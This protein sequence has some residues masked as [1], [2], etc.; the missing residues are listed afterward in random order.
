M[1]T[2][3]NCGKA[4][5]PCVFSWS[6]AGGRASFPIHTWLQGQLVHLFRVRSKYWLYAFDC[7]ATLSSACCWAT[8]FPLPAA[9]GWPST[10]RRTGP[11]QQGPGEDQA[12]VCL[13]KIGPHLHH[14]GVVIIYELS[15]EHGA[16]S[17]VS[18]YFFK[19]T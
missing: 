14:G 10:A 3:A 5:M 16:A 4:Y 9:A 11:A 6:S 18:V 15:Q 13:E 19:D 12:Q 2:M 7:E 1:A 17:A 8:S